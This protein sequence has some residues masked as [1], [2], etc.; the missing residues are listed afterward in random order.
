MNR[1]ARLWLL[2]CGTPIVLLALLALTLALVRGDGTRAHSLLVLDLSGPIEEQGAPS[3]LERLLEGRPD[4]VLGL[5]ALL[6]AASADRRISALL[7]RVGGL[8]VG[9]AKAD[10]LRDQLRRFQDSGKPT[11]ALVEFGGT[12]DYYVA[13]ACRKVYVAPEGVLILR[14]VMADM[15]FLRGTL[16]RLRVQAEFVSA[17]RYKSAPEMFTRTEPSP[18]AREA[19]NSILDQAYA[20]LRDGIAESRRLPPA[21]VDALI[22]RALFRGP[23]AV[24]T[25]LADEALYE[26]QVVD[27]LGKEAHAD[28]HLLPHRE[29]RR[30]SRAD[31]RGETIAVVYAAGEI[32]PGRQGPLGTPSGFMDADAVAEA[33]RSVREDERVRAVILRV[34]S[35]G[36]AVTAADRIWREVSLTRGEK[37]VVVSM[38]DVAASGGYWIATPASRVVAAPVTLTGSIGVFA[39]KFNLQGLYHWAGMRREILK[40]GENANLF[41]DYG[42][43]TPAQ[44]GRIQEEIDATYREFIGRVVAGR[45]LD[46]VRAGEAAEGRV[47]T[48]SQA[49]ERGLVDALGGFDQALDE[50]R[51]LAGLEPGAPV[52]LEFHP[53]ER[54][55]LE[56]LA[57]GDLEVL[58]RPLRRLAALLEVTARWLDGGAGIQSRHDGLGVIP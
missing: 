25:S 40:R 50:A 19:A 18:A 14:G 23:A 43:F 7:V 46:A 51:Q 22:D 9:F 45:G 2:G 24:Q 8:E 16:D 47:W 41:S 31:E 26:D 52:R 11:A 6:R 48:G 54:G 17:G 32:V 53:R 34:D 27:R 15:P 39:G 37:P 49:R 38:S 1:K 56:S 20:R 33:L 55:L 57:R 29:Y 42:A 21:R 36:G 58:A 5:R 30:G 35:P 44:R 28:L 4:T 3:A 12:L 10:E 13:S